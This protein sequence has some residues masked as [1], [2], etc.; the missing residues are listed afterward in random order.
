MIRYPLESKSSY[1]S[2]NSHLTNDFFDINLV[3][4]FYQ[5][6]SDLMKVSAKIY[7]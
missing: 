6:C 1:F 5:N 3:N 4:L 2:L 7:T